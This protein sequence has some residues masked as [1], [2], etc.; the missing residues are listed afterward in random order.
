[1]RWT[2]N[3]RSVPMTTP[4]GTVAVRIDGD[5]EGSPLLLCQRFRGT[6]EDWDPE[7]VALLA[8]GRKVIRFDCTG[9]GESDGVAPNTVHGMAEIVPAL[10]DALN[11]ETIDLL[12][13]SLGG[14]VAQTVALDRPTRVRRLVI[15]GSGPG[16]PD[17]PPPDPR[18][19]EM[20]RSVRPGRKRLAHH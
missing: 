9:V 15:A 10:L 13:W 8:R 1:M 4:F 17:G 20:P 5:P 6:M 3:D 7:F 2:I 18:V 14:Y 16:G 11:I 19:A 12:G